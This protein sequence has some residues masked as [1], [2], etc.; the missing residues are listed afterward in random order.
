MSK[1]SFISKMAQAIDDVSMK[2]KY[3]SKEEALEAL[4]RAGVKD[5]ELQYSG[6]ED[7]IQVDTDITR[8]ILQDAASKRQDEFDFLDT[9]EIAFNQEGPAFT[10]TFDDLA[11]SYPRGEYSGVTTALD[12]EEAIDD[13]NYREFIYQFSNA[14]E[15]RNPENILGSRSVSSHYM[16]VPNYMGHVRTLDEIWDGEKVLNVNEVQSDVLGHALKR[17]GYDEDIYVDMDVDDVDR[18]RD[19][20]EEFPVGDYPDLY[21]SALAEHGDEINRLLKPHTALTIDD[22]PASE[23]YD[24]LRYGEREAASGINNSGVG[25]GPDR[26]PNTKNYR[27]RMLERSLDVAQREGKTKLVVPLEDVPEMGMPIQDS[28]HRGDHIQKQEYNVK[29]GRVPKA[30]Q[31][32]ARDQGMEYSTTEKDGILYGVI[33]FKDKKKKP[34][35]LYSV[36]GLLGAGALQQIM[37]DPS[38]DVR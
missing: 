20:A 22:I 37:Q 8:D 31:K 38:Q 34:T 17:G 19:L 28:L 36:G 1:K 30:M 6:L 2:A 23:A 15:Q 16:D 5:A 7:L 9:R 29:K 24:F 4:R 13:K 10:Q 27:E 25:P 33:D 26:F 18:L 12:P 14:P 3:K 35:E 21:D 32:I 11:D